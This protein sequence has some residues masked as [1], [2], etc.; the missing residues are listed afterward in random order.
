MLHVSG[1]RKEEYALS[2]SSDDDS[3]SLEVD[4]EGQMEHT[5]PRDRSCC[6]C[7]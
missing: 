3:S 7:H 4:V 5:V 6:S 2:Y 1:S